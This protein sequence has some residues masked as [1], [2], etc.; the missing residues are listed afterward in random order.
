MRTNT[1]GKRFTEWLPATPVEPAM[2]DEVIRF[3]IEHGISMSELQRQALALFL[4][5]NVSLTNTSS[6][7]SD[8]E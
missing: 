6:R 4:R 1:K 7:L 8:K 5:G 3:G 2:R